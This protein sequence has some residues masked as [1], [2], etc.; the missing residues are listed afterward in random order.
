MIV[1]A[2]LMSSATASPLPPVAC[3]PLDEGGGFVAADL[4]GDNNGVITQPEWAVGRSGN[5][6]R[7]TPGTSILVPPVDE[8]LNLLD[9]FTIEMWIYP[10]NWSL[11]QYAGLI[12]YATGLDTQYMLAKSPDGTLQFSHSNDGYRNVPGPETWDNGRWYHVVVVVAHSDNKIHFYRDGVLEQTSR[13]MFDEWPILPQKDAELLIGVSPPGDAGFFDGLIDEI[14]LYPDQLSDK[15]ILASYENGQLG[16]SAC[17]V[18]KETADLDGDGFVMVDDCDDTDPDTYPDA[19]E[20]CDDIDNDC[21]DEIDEDAVDM[22][23]WCFDADDDAY[24]DSSITTVSCD[25]PPG[26]TSNCDDCNDDDFRI[27]PYNVEDECPES[28]DGIDNNCDGQVDEGDTPR[29]YV[30]ADGDGYGDP[31]TETVDCAQPSGTVDNGDD[32]NDADA[33]TWPGAP[34]LDE[35][36][37]PTPLLDCGCSER[38][39]AAWVVVPLLL[40]LRRRR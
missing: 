2:A 25:L 23:T 28:N 12:A 13:G 32:C 10:E 34:G 15:E 17:E 24:G 39:A 30:D 9:D 19:D 7:F 8:A 3:W 18:F 37:Q 14:V 40:G 29:W 22:I 36:C 6:I 20:R 27:S 31:A 1:L 35:L 11:N 21:D 5:A 33:S 38:T 26:F 16:L 4:I